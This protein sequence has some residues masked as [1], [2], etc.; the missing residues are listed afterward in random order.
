MIRL[1]R[2]IVPRPDR[3]VEIFQYAINGKTFSNFGPLHEQLKNELSAIAGGWALPVTS[4]TAAIE[5]ALRTL[6][7]EPGARVALPDFTHSGTL[8]A[9]VRAGL[10]PVL[11]G[12][13]P[14]TWTITA[15]REL[16]ELHRVAAVVVVSPFG[17]PVDVGAWENFSK[18][19]SVPIVYDLA[20][21][22][23]FFPVTKNPRCYSLHATKNMGIGE[24]GFVVFDTVAEREVARRLINFDT[25]PDRSI[26]S[27][28]GTNAKVDELHAAFVLAAIEKTHRVRV[29][30][31][32]ADKRTLVRF[33]VEQLAGT[34]IPEAIRHGAPSFPSL[35]VLGSLPAAELEAASDRLG[36]TFKRY[37]PLLSRMPAV[38][39]VERI[40]V[41][42]DELETCCALPSD[43]DLNQAFQVV[44]TVRRFLKR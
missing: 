25:L 20:G 6:R 1:I 23:G 40:S 2:P 18:A 44:D 22:W 43:V 29:D 24:G 28:N 16:A 10:T 42:G 32:I 19:Y 13:D 36:V 15:T 5:V 33:Y 38:A 27:L 30:R 34:T 21:A 4:G 12:V 9:V 14:K 35:C 31:R 7:L 11:V 8:L 3:A 39:G 26:A 17:Y 37:Y 41:S